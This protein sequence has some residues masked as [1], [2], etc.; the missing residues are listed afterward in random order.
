MKVSEADQAA[1]EKAWDKVKD[2]TMTSRER[3]YALWSAVLSVTDNAVPGCFVECGV[4][5]GGSAMLM[6]LALKHRGVFRQIV[7]FDT[8]AGMSAPGPDDVDI[9]GHHASELMA[10]KNGADIAELVKAEAPLEQVKQALESTG[11]DMRFV[12]FVVGDVCETL[13][14]TQTLN[15]A[16][17]RL[18]TDFYDST[19]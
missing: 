11:Y 7:L 6:A 18:D 12:R 15:I 3:G 19:L 2:F 14:C 13:P 5:K 17:L 16:L 1:F 9:G 10:G 8:F 4:W